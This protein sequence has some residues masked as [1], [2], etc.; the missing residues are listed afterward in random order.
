M[1]AVMKVFA[2][3]PGTGKTWRAAR[4]AVRILAPDTPDTKVQGV[5]ESLV[6]EGRII[7]V[8]FH[9]SYSYEDFV[10]GFRPE[11]TEQG[12]I[13]YSIL[14]GPFRKAC[15]TAS[16]AVS[17]NRFHV[18]QLLGPQ[19]RYEVTHVEA[20]GLVLQTVANKRK[21]A[22]DEGAAGFVDFWTLQRFAEHKCPVADLRIP[23]TQNERKQEVAR[24]VGI[25]TTFFNNSG[26]HAAVYEA[27]LEGG[28]K[29]EPMPTVLVIDEINR[30]DLSRV[31]GE[32]ITLLEFDKRQGA[33]EERAVT[34]AYSGTP[35]TVPAEL[36]IIGTMNT[37]DKSLSAVDLALRRRFEFILMS[38]NPEL[39]PE[40]YGGINVRKLFT[41]MNRRL[42][43]L[44]GR[45][46]LIGHADFMAEKLE[47]LRRREG[48]NPNQEGRLKVVAHTLRLKIVPFLADLFRG[49]WNNVR[50]VVR[51]KLFDEEDLKDLQA[52]LEDFGGPETSGMWVMGDWWNP[53]GQWD[54]TRARAAI[55]KP[56]QEGFAELPFPE[57]D[58]AEKLN[59]PQAAN[60]VGSVGGHKEAAPI[61]VGDTPLAQ[62]GTPS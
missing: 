20:G 44:N 48:Y 39:T 3:P 45:E 8:T 42:T 38:P 35:L 46:N 17:P 31:F 2:G 4:E 21:D 23:G 11:E 49:D 12:N 32:L 52:E 43:A 53:R 50:F 59:A 40:A 33:A 16:A 5:H 30:A 26:R 22:V 6:R 56:S 19:D 15:R 57:A 37:A 54:Q 14:P 55:G 62:A 10:E 41:D 34:L 27:L 9:P 25:P 58:D 51:T 47:E 61:E 18:G 28:A 60:L 13:T 24:L 29:P 36:S 7:W 1:T